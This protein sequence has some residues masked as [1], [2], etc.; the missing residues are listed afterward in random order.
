[1][2]NLIQPTSLSCGQH[3]CPIHATTGIRLAEAIAAEKL[4]EYGSF[5]CRFIP[6]RDAKASAKRKRPTTTQPCGD[7][8]D[9]DTKDETFA[10]SVSKGEHDG[11]SLD[12]G[13][14]D[15]GIGNEEVCI[16]IF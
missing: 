11:N 1:M 12:S 13:S 16:I 10:I 4:D 14:D 7:A 15:I 6:A 8:I 2:P 9:T 3:S 5:C